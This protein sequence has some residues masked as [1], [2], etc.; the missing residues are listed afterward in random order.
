MQLKSG[1]GSWPGAKE[2][3]LFVRLF[4]GLALGIGVRS[5]AFQVQNHLELRFGRCH[6]QEMN[7]R[8]L[9]I[10]N[11]NCW[12]PFSRLDVRD[13]GKHGAATA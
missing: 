11:H 9:Q 7:Q 6:A 8:A 1:L 5:E 13:S 2:P 12:Q 10:T 3:V 4:V